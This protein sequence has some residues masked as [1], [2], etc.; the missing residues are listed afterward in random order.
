VQARDPGAGANLN[1]CLS[2]KARR[3]K[4][5]VGSNSRSHTLDAEF[6]GSRA[7][8]THGFTLGYEL[9]SELPAADFVYHHDSLPNDIADGS[10][11]PAFSG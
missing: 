1:Y 10:K 3:E 2:L 7:S 8:V 4:S 9:L 6:F 5:Q 11:C